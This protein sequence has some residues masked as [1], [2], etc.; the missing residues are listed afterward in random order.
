MCIR[1]RVDILVEPEGESIAG[2]AVFLSF[3]NRFLDIVDSDSEKARIQP[4]KISQEVPEN[5]GIFDNDTHAA[6]GNE[7][8]L[9]QIDYVHTSIGGG[10]FITD[11]TVIGQITFKPKLAISS[12]S[13]IFDVDASV[14]RITEVTVVNSEKTQ[15]QVELSNMSSAVISIGGGPILTKTF[16]PI[17]VL[18]GKSESFNLNDY[19]TDSNDSNDALT[20]S[21]EGDHIAV[22]INQST[23]LAT[24]S[25]SNEVVGETEVLFTVRDP[26]GN[27]ASGT[28]SY[29]HLTLPTSD[30]V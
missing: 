6:P 28:V 3:D 10:D 13:I 12:T 25:V 22:E 5:W 16:L 30:L 21:A 18:L 24:L 1:D 23:H 4:V 29:T 8:D 2:F 11:P 9:F 20:W 7:I 27:S 17:R 15:Q 14:S 19:V 26:K